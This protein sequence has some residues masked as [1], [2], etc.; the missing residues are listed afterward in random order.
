MI[1]DNIINEINC[2]NLISKKIILLEILINKAECY[3]VKILYKNNIC[4][5]KIYNETQLNYYSYDLEITAY[6]NI[7]KPY[8]PEFIDSLHCNNSNYRVII[9]SYLE[10]Y[11]NLN[12]I[13][14]TSKNEINNIYINL[15]NIIKDLH[16]TCIHKDIKNDNLMYNQ[17]TKELK[18]I[19]LGIS[20]TINKTNDKFIFY[21]S[22]A[23]DWQSPDFIINCFYK[24]NNTFE[25]NL[26]LAKKNDLFSIICVIINILYPKK[27]NFNKQGILPE[28]IFSIESYVDSIS[29]YD[30]IKE[31]LIKN[32]NYLDNTNTINININYL[33]SFFINNLDKEYNYLLEYLINYNLLQNL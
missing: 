31:Y 8:L 13:I 26:E 11:I 18:I 20:Y 1:I 24:I 30:K 32:F 17:L 33:I 29:Y 19:D 15:L 25:Y 9:I 6:K 2:D 5:A 23:F 10:N 14:F 21:N 22:M 12:D 7:K 16:H 4:I 27:T 28:Y 3:V